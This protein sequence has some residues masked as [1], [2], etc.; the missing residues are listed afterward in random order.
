MSSINYEESGYNLDLDL[1]RVSSH[2][3]RSPTRFQIMMGWRCS[4]VNKHKPPTNHIMVACQ[5]VGGCGHG[6]QDFH[7]PTKAFFNLQAPVVKGLKTGYRRGGGFN[8]E[9]E[10]SRWSRFEKMIVASSHIRTLPNHIPFAFGRVCPYSHQKLVGEC[11][12]HGN[13]P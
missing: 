12:L 11:G 4:H 9:E 7:T 8:L 1:L 6:P 10:V 13:S 2:V 3:G 5:N